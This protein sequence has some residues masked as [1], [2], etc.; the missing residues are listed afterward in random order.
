MKISFAAVHRKNDF[1]VL[2]ISPVQKLCPLQLRGKG[3]Q[4]KAKFPEDGAHFTLFD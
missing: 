2:V 1:S 3:L 4:D